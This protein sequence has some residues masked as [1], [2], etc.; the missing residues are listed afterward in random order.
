MKSWGT[1]MV[2]ILMKGEILQKVMYAFIV[3]FYGGREVGWGV[4]GS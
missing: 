1:M 3:F 4:S 2:Y